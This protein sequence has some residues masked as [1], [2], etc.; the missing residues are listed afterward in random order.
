VHLVG[1]AIGIYY[2]A[3]TYELQKV[4]TSVASLC[5]CKGLWHL[6]DGIKSNASLYPV[7]EQEVRYLNKILLSP[8]FLFE[9]VQIKLIYSNLEKCENFSVFHSRLQT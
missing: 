3:Q 7:F 9:I 6:C 8:K 1:F 5:P 2:Y 4:V